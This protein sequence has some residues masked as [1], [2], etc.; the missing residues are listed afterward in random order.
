VAVTFVT[1]FARFAPRL[2]SALVSRPAL[3]RLRRGKFTLL[4]NAEV[5]ELGSSS[6]RVESSVGHLTEVPAQLLVIAAPGS[7]DDR[8]IAAALNARQRVI[9]IGEASL[10]GMTLERAIRDAHDVAMRLGT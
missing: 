8:L 4:T 2:E 7:P 6:C 3:Q 1:G 10:P 9:M 5:L